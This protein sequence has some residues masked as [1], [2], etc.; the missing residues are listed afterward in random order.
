MGLK[1]PDERRQAGK[2]EH[3]TV[4]LKAFNTSSYVNIVISDDGKGIDKDKVLKKAIEKGLVETDAVLTEE[5]TLNLIF[6]PGSINRI[7]YIGCIRPWRGNG[8]R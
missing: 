1:H 4:K 6:H 8:C 7:S 5:E 2:T 3:G